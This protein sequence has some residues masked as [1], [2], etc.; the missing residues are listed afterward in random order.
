[1]YPR[2]LPSAQIWVLFSSESENREASLFPCCFL[3]KSIVVTWQSLICFLSGGS[4][5][6]GHPQHGQLV[7][8]WD[9][10]RDEKPPFSGQS[11]WNSGHTEGTEVRQML[12]LH[13]DPYSPMRTFTSH[14]HILIFPP[15]LQNPVSEAAEQR[16]R[17]A[18]EPELLHGVR[19]WPEKKGLGW[20]DLNCDLKKKN[21]K[22]EE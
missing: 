3:W 1:M 7:H 20:I 6:W 17:Q 10:H 14:I 2:G 21:L 13:R 18:E 8:V 5:A 11:V 22:K 12:Q 19:S 16:V 15:Q 4:V 9:L